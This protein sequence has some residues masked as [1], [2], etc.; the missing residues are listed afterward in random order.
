MEKCST[1]TEVQ[2]ETY[3]SQEG[4]SLREDGI[5]VASVHDVGSETNSVNGSGVDR[6]SSGDKKLNESY[7]NKYVPYSSVVAVQIQENYERETP[8]YSDELVVGIGSVLGFVTGVAI[9]SDGGVF[10]ILLSFV[11]LV[12]ALASAIDKQ[13]SEDEFTKIEIVTKSEI[14]NISISTEKVNDTELKQVYQELVSHSNI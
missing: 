1:V 3:Y 10:V 9:G 13:K 4:V 12:V 7:T 2:N 5:Y 11:A 8:E 14:D 6:G